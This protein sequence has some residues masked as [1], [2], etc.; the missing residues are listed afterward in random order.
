[1]RGLLV[2]EPGELPEATRGWKE[3]DY[4]EHAMSSRHWVV[5][6]TDGELIVPLRYGDDKDSERTKGT[7]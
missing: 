6:D 7:V 2:G 1:M 4:V 5:M 3:V